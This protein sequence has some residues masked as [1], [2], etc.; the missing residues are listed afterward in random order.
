MRSLESK[1]E[2]RKIV[3]SKR[4]AL[5][6]DER[7]K[8]SA[9]IRDRLF[10]QPLYQ[11]A[12]EVYCYV[13]FEEEV[14]TYGIL[15]HVWKS[16]RRL[17]VPKILTDSGPFMRMEFFYIESLADL[18]K[19]YFGIPEPDEDRPA[20]NPDSGKNVLAVMPGVAFDKNRRRIGYGKGFYDAYLKRHP[21]YWTIALAYSIQCLDSIP[22]REHDIRPEM[23]IT[24]REIYTC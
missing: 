4:A 9:L 15:E 13:S 24:E 11:Q 6:E 2:I 17:A 21:D 16:G 8:Y 5:P 7:L 3:R 10:D 18:K 23:I 20:G 14:I 12:D 22:S 19:G 1:K